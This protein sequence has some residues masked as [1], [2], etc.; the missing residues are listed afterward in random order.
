[1]NNSQS[2]EKIAPALLT[3]SQVCAYLNIARATFYKINVTGAFG[4]LPV[5][6]GTCRKVLYRKDEIENWV[7]AGCPHRKIWQ[8][9]RKEMK[10]WKWRRKQQLQKPVLGGDRLD[11][12]NYGWNHILNFHCRQEAISKRISV[13]SCINSKVLLLNIRAES[14]G[15]FLRYCFGN[16]VA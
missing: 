16:I 12:I 10:L 13:C 5:K 6:L 3:I 8:A 14:A 7:R 9:Q 4:L 15:S 2:P 1:M 11:E